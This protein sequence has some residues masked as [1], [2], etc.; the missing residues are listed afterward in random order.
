MKIDYLKV[1]IAF[2]SSINILCKKNNSIFWINNLRLYLFYQ[3]VIHTL[4]SLL[5]PTSARFRI[6]D[7]LPT[8]A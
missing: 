5:D 7:E 4:E 2:G 1:L 8:S 3:K 6:P